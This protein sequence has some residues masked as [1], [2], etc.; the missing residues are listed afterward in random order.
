M[1]NF[2]RG[3]TVEVLTPY[4]MEPEQWHAATVLMVEQSSISVMFTQG[5]DKGKVIVLEMHLQGR[6]WR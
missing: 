3:D 2:E 4:Y 6:N 5:P 1:K